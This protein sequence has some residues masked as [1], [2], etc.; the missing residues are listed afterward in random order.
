VNASHDDSSSSPRARRRLIFLLVG[1]LAVALAALL[2]RARGVDEA[3]YGRGPGVWIAYGLSRATGWIPVSLAELVVVAVVARQLVGAGRGLGQIRR[4]RRSLP[5]TVAAGGLRLGQDVGILVALFYVTWGFNY[6]R[7]PLEERWQWPAEVPSAA[8]DSTA[9][10]TLAAEMVV[11]TNEA[12]LALH[13]TEDAGSPTE[14]TDAAGLERRIEGAWQDLARQL[15]LAEPTPHRY[16]HIK[17]P[18]LSP[19]MDRLG[20]SGF[21]F[22]FTGEANVNGGIPASSVPLAMAHEKAHQRGFAPEDEANFMGYLVCATAHDDLARYSA[23]LFA[24]RQL[25]GALLRIDP[26][27]VEDLLPRRMAGVQRD[28]DFLRAYWNRFRGPARTFSHKVNDAYLRSN[29]VEGGIESYG[30]SV[31]LLLRY[32]YHYRTLVPSTLPPPH[33][34][35]P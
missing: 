18:L 15:D 17:R 9:V 27:R 7:P 29:R 8:F 5:R 28:V 25:L 10:Y 19:L 26:R 34:E 24:Q 6:A 4:D 30:R 22:P 23:F 12:Y 14:W 2:S 35:E 21:Y 31:D 11:R 16:G 1:V 3:L 32:A 20:I 13:H 33:G